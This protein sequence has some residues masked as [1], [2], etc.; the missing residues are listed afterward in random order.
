MSVL[1]HLLVVQTLTAIN[2]SPLV[3][4][5]THHSATLSNNITEST[6]EV[7][8]LLPV[9]GRRCDEGFAIQ[10][11]VLIPPSD[12]LARVVIVAGNVCSVLCSKLSRFIT[13]ATVAQGQSIATVFADEMK[14]LP[15]QFYCNSSGRGGMSPPFSS[16]VVVRANGY[17]SVIDV[18]RV[19]D[20]GAHL[21][22]SRCD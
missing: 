19:T 6:S 8:V 12:H 15:S 16:S 22:A 1:T 4:R 5:N 17:L 14:S 13:G 11:S 3:H 10:D 21:V 20:G 9:A 7:C 18:C 2:H